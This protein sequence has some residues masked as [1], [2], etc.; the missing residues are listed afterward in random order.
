MTSKVFLLFIALLLMTGC[1]TTTTPRILTDD[2]DVELLKKMKKWEGSH[3]SQ[4]IQRLG[5]PT[6]KTSD[7]AGG[8]IYVWRIDPASLP[9]LPAHPP[10][11]NPPAQTPTSSINSAISQAASRFLHQEAVRRRIQSHNQRMEVY[12]KILAMKQMFYVR[13]DGTIY[14]AHL[15]YHY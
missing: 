12:Q 7:E 3:I 15:M 11:V 5:P 4:L 2:F 13:P 6:Y 14:L 10:L 8:T 9:P 1:A